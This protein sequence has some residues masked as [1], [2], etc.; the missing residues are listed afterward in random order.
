MRE[1][2]K[3]VK[4]KFLNIK[5]FVLG[6]VFENIKNPHDRKQGL[7]RNALI[8]YVIKLIKLYID[9]KHSLTSNW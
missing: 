5:G 8:E 6:S 7:F 4:R 1:Y 3:K 2:D 9:Y